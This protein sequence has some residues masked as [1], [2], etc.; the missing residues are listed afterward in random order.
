[1][2]AV[3]LDVS[4]GGKSTL[5]QISAKL[6]VILRVALGLAMG[7]S[8]T[9]SDMF[10]PLSEAI[11][12]ISEVALAPVSM[13]LFGVDTTMQVVSVTLAS[14]FTVLSNRIQ[15][16]RYDRNTMRTLSTD[17]NLP[18]SRLA[19]LCT[20][21]MRGVLVELAE[22]LEASGLPFVA[23]YESTNAILCRLDRGERAD[24]AILLDATIEQLTRSGRLLAESR[25]ELARSGVAIAVRA[26]AEKPDISTVD[27]FRR[28][29]LSA[30]SIAYTRTGASGLHFAAV[31]ERLGI[32]D[33]VNRKARVEDGLVGEL[34]ARG[35]VAIAVQQMS[36]L[37]PVG[38][39]DI[40][41]QLPTEVQKMSVFSG[42]IFADTAHADAGR[43]LIAYLGS[44]AAESAIRDNGLEP[45]RSAA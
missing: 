40:V 15:G 1:M 16:V 34:A 30:A 28:A 8:R 31:I 45:A 29:L 23:H 6:L 2:D 32:A 5:L 4:G 18:S 26:G 38:G 41:G 14:L 39:I 24:V 42:G 3:C 36:E 37:R 11:R 33:E 35:E 27:A 9:C 43:Q 21:G 20:L 10:E 13:L 44:V 25:R 17:P 22:S 7:V 19:I 12:P